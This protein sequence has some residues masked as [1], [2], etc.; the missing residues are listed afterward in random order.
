MHFNLTCRLYANINTSKAFS[1]KV[2]VYYIKDNDFN[3]NFAIANYSNNSKPLVATIK[4]TYLKKSS[5][6][7]IMFLS[8]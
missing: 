8:R 2:I 1:F 6:K 4:T 7:P 5:I 3:F